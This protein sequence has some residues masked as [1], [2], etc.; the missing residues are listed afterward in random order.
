MDFYYNDLMAQM[1]SE[2]RLADLHRDAKRPL[3]PAPVRPRQTRG[4]T[5]EFA[6]WVAAR[7]KIGDGFMAR[8]PMNP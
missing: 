5:R 8:T 4:W 7:A 2:R 6:A 1:E 3:A